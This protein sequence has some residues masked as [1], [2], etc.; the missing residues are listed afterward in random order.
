MVQRTSAVD[1]GIRRILI[2]RCGSVFSYGTVNI[3][4]LVSF[5]A[6]LA[7]A[8]T[9][10]E[11]N[12][13]TFRF[14]SLKCSVLLLMMHTETVVR[15]VHC[16]SMLQ[17]VSQIGMQAQHACKCLIRAFDGKR[18]K[19]STE[20]RASWFRCSFCLFRDQRCRGMPRCT[21]A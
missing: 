17:Q 13:A 15:E 3:L 19:I 4:S 20:V 7:L 18:S 9:G 16:S 8:R 1:Y 10:R 21:V 2:S 6:L 11:Q 12:T 14:H 5:S